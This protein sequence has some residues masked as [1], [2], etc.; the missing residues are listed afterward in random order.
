MSKS[1][2]ARPKSA[3]KTAAAPAQAPGNLLLS[4]SEFESICDQLR[5]LTHVTVDAWATRADYADGLENVLVKLHAARR[6]LETAVG[7]AS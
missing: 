6:N 1:K 4:R 2:V 3:G 7:V 5:E